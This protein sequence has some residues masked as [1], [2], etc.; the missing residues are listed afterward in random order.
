VS[1]L[2]PHI[3][4]L[5]DLYRLLVIE[6]EQARFERDRT[7]WLRAWCAN[8]SLADQLP[9]ECAIIQLAA[10]NFASQGWSWLQ[11]VLADDPTLLT[12]D[13]LRQLAHRIA[14]F[15]GGGR[16]RLKVDREFG[17]DLLQRF[18]TDDGHGDGRLTPDF[19]RLQESV[20]KLYSQ[21]GLSGKQLSA[22]NDLERAALSGVIA[23]RAEMRRALQQYFDLEEAE[24]A[25]PLWEQAFDEPSPGSR[26]VNQ[27]HDSRWDRLRLQ[28]FLAIFQPLVHRKSI[29]RT[30]QAAEFATQTR[31]ATLVSIALTVYHRRHIQWP[32]RLEQ[33]C[34]DLLPEV[35]LDRFDGEPLRYRIVDDRPLL[36]SVGRN[37]ID[38]GGRF[39]PENNGPEARD[40]DWR[41]WPVKVPL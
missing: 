36:Y 16:L 30:W 8:L 9:P 3:E 13:D 37:R 11:T 41:L 18:Y 27:W 10:F 1:V 28:T 5:S 20:Q 25:K 17:E 29:G 24:S 2:L 7:R 6:V 26:L 21:A 19:F 32:E 34:P 22:V 35:P 4:G 15:Q 31:D 33:L 12:D 39:P 14:A 40:G 23:S 38:E